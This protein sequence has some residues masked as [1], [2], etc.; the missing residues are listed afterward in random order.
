MPVFWV[1]AGL[2]AEAGRAAGGLVVAGW[3]QGEPAELRSVVAK[4]ADVEVFDQD[5]DRGS[6]VPPADA[7]VVELAAIAEGDRA[8]AVDCV[9]ADPVV[10]WQLQPGRQQVDRSHDPAGRSASWSRPPAAT[11]PSRSRRATTSSPPPTR[12][13]QTS[14]TP[15]KRSTP[16]DRKEADRLCVE[17][18]N[19]EAEL[20]HVRCTRGTPGVHARHPPPGMSVSPYDQR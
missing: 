11:A 18:A 19:V 14:A 16:T 7:N 9:V 1:V 13:P 17:R 10:C 12:C 3:V 15:S 2:R 8:A 4:D 20:V 5:D 6:C